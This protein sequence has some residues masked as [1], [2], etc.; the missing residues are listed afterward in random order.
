MR[1][2]W[3]LREYSDKP[4]PGKIYRKQASLTLVT[5]ARAANTKLPQSFAYIHATLAFVCC[6]NTFW[7]ID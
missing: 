5:L 7:I 4:W 3:S 1:M 6:M 2:F